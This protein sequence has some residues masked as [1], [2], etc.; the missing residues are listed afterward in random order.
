MGL[1]TAFKNHTRNTSCIPL[2]KTIKNAFHIDKWILSTILTEKW[3]CIKCFETL[4]Q[5]I[6]N[7]DIINYKDRYNAS[8][9]AIAS[10]KKIS[11]FTV[12]LLQY[13]AC[14]L[15]IGCDGA[16]VPSTYAQ[17][18]NKEILFKAIQEHNSCDYCKEYLTFKSSSNYYPLFTN[19]LLQDYNP[20]Y[21]Q[22]V[23][24]YFNIDERYGNG[25]TWLYH[26]VKQYID[27][28]S[29]SIDVIEELLKC[30]ADIY[31][32]ADNGVSLLD[33]SKQNETIYNLLLMY[34]TPIKY[35]DQT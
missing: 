16:S 6:N 7:M 20:I 18:V 19:A 12:L 26:K 35:P 10:Q 31:I 11:D 15:L 1:I 5:K 30:G 32:V 23:T 34:D 14:P 13:G 2:Q 9:L 3:V 21:V 24:K 27:R 25:E 4:L 33:L 17:M 8:P 29:S 22:L 28:Y